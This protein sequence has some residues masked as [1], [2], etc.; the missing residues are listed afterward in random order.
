M[1]TYLLFNAFTS[2]NIQNISAHTHT[3]TCDGKDEN[4]DERKGNTRRFSSHSKNFKNSKKP[5]NH[6]KTTHTQKNMMEKMKN[7]IGK[8]KGEKKKKTHTSG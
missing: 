7:M 1:Y 2:L 5:H 3:H 4:D 8:G 6:T